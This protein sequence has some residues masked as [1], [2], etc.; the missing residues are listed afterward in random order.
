ML[1]CPSDIF[2]KTNVMLLEEVFTLKRCFLLSPST[3]LSKKSLEINLLFKLQSP[4]LYMKK[5]NMSIRH[6]NIVTLMKSGTP[7]F[8][9]DVMYMIDL[10]VKYFSVVCLSIYQEKL[11]V[12]MYMICLDVKYFS[13]VCLSIYQ[14]KLA[15]KTTLTTMGHF[16]AKKLNYCPSD[17]IFNS[18]GLKYQ[19]L[20]HT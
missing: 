20:K 19:C 17:I 11:A 13:V 14:E 3:Q 9:F 18:V 12:I 8:H 15:V 16:F 5:K 4:I 7:F 2:S 6:N 10:D 1:I